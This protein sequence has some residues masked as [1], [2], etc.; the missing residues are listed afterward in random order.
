M[1]PWLRGGVLGVLLLTATPAWAVFTFGTVQSAVDAANLS[2]YTYTGLTDPGSNT[3]LVLFIYSSKGSLPDAVTSASGWGLTFTL[4]GGA[5]DTLTFSSGASSKR[6]TVMRARGATTAADLVIAFGGIVQLA[7]DFIMVPVTDGFDT[8][9][10]NGSGAAGQSLSG[11][12]AGVVTIPVTMTA[13]DAAVACYGVD[14]TLAGGINPDAGWTEFIDL[15][16]TNPGRRFEGQGVTTPVTV[17]SA[18]AS[19]GT[20]SMG[21]IFVEL[22]ASGGAAPSDFFFR[23]RTSGGG[24]GGGAPTG[25]VAV[26]RVVSW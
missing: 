24:G 14:V 1:I 17:A 3:L 7:C 13:G 21:G 16:S 6:I 23:R 18:T 10:T 20:P 19:T 15:T 9:G 11:I 5:D 2:T 25:G 22:K 26:A 4:W 8:S 12:G